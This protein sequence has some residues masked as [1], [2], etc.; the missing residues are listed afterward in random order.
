MPCRAGTPAAPPAADDWTLISQGND[1][2]IYSRIH[3]GG[4]IKEYK[5]VGTINATP[6]VLLAVLDDVENYPHFMPY[7]TEC[8]ILKREKGTL[9]S[10]Q[11]VSPPFCTDRDYT[12]RVTHQTKTSAAGPVYLC[13]WEPANDL[14]PAETGNTLRVKTNEGSWLVEPAP[15]TRPKPPT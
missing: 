9:I 10:Y 5:A 12:L 6:R 14:G 13:H 2:S 8:R 15:A 7:I 11:R 3:P 4:E 1:I